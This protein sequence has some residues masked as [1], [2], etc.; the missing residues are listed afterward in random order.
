MDG[1][2][3][4]EEAKLVG[5]VVTIFNGSSYD[6]MFREVEP[7]TV[8]GERISTYSVDCFHAGILYEL[9]SGLTSPHNVSTAW[10]QLIQD[11]RSVD[12]DSV[13]LNWECCSACGDHCFPSPFHTRQSRSQRW[14]SR[15]S[16]Q[17][18]SLTMRLIGFAL[19]AGYTVLC[20]DFSLKS[21]IFE[22]SEEELGPNPFMK[23]GACH[24]YFQIEFVPSEL[25]NEEVPQQL[26]VVGELCSEQGKASVAANGNTIVYTVNPHRASTALYDL[27]VLTVVTAHDGVEVP[28]ALHCSVGS[29]TD[30][31]KNG[32]VR[33]GVAGH[34]ALTYAAGGQL[35]TSMGHWI[36]LT[37]INT[38]M[39][40][41]IRVAEHEFGYEEAGNFRREFDDLCTAE[42]RVEC[43]QKH[44]RSL[45]SKS[46]PSRM[47]CRTKF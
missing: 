14:H 40:D 45:V 39:E 29:D 12:P 4:K 23:V 37:R 27:K 5:V 13:V 2:A 35:V 8:P 25:Q 18:P 11:L 15:R 36:E 16:A 26:Q 9:L 17:P 6:E 24:E 30:G 43:V 10:Q 33:R 41:V 46:V 34:V 44:A 1:A 19:R 7:V 28:E 38:S 32:K 42:E 20:S 3:L 47:K 31:D 22:W 21:L